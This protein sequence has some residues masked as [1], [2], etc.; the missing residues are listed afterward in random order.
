[1]RPAPVGRVEQCGKAASTAAAAGPGPP[2]P[3]HPPHR[4]PP[5]T[6]LQAVPPQLGRLRRLKVLQLDGNAVAAVPPEVLHGCTALATLS[7]H[8]N[9]ISPDALAATDGCAVGACS[10]EPG[11]AQQGSWAQACR[12]PAWPWHAPCTAPARHAPPSA[13]LSG[14]ARCKA[15]E[16]QQ[17]VLAERAQ[18]SVPR[19]R[20]PLHT[21]SPPAPARFAEY[22]ARRQGKYTKTLAGGALLGSNGMDEGLDR[23]GVSPRRG[24]TA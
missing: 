2:S 15:R 24:A 22:E 9:P 10:R 18:Q 3:S 6:P 5:R 12:A 8:D 13:A 17:V 11:A 20:L 4:R 23:H 7:L 1:M 21:R 19:R 16:Q 14:S